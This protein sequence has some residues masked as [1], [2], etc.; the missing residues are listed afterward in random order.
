MNIN[1]MI[2]HSKD[3]K[4]FSL[5]NGIPQGYDAPVISG[6][7]MF[8]LLN[9]T[10]TIVIQQFVNC[11]FR[12]CHNSICFSEQDR[13]TTSLEDEGLH[14]LIALDNSIVLYKEGHSIT[15]EKDHAF[16]CTN[17]DVIH[18][19][20]KPGITYHLV[21]LSFSIDLA[22]QFDS[23]IKRFEKS[24]S[25]FKNA[26]HQSKPLYLIPAIKDII[27]QIIQNPYDGDT[28]EAYLEI[29]LKE[30]FFVLMQH[31]NRN[32]FTAISFTDYELN[33]IVEARKILLGDISKKPYTITQLSRLAG[34][35]SFKLK[36]GFRQLYGMGVFECLQEKRMEYAKELLMYTAKPIKEISALAG[37][38]RMTNFIT[39]FRRKF[40]YTPGSLRRK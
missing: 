32:L 19:C 30:L 35:N 8:Y 3:N 20:C 2:I 16:F 10:T 28:S 17:S 12:F 37:Y 31:H 25:A 15:I 4:Y 36:I 21:T 34:I 14:L 29:K 18:I 40:G 22:K 38:P 13:Y 27:R 11:E 1:E 7:N 26:F 9:K 5:T 24:E 39:A 6:T 33:R 23:F